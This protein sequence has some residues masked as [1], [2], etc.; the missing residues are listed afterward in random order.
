[1]R[2]KTLTFKSPDRMKVLTLVFVVAFVFSPQVRVT[3]A[4]VLY[5][6]ADMIS[7]SR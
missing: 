3:T 5:S 4:N 7:E 6:L 1:M 2:S